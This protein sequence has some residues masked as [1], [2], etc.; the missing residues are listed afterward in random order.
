MDKL[1]YD[2]VDF[3]NCCEFNKYVEYNIND[4]LLQYAI[5]H[6]SIKTRIEIL[7][8]KIKGKV[9]KVI[10]YVIGSIKNCL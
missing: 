10:N 7:L 2:K 4:C 3:S 8:I 5:E 1:N 6:P 9:K